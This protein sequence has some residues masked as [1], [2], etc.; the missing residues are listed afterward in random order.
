MCNEQFIIWKKNSGEGWARHVPSVL[1]NSWIFKKHTFEHKHVFKAFAHRLWW[2]L[3]FSVHMNLNF[4]IG[5]FKHTIPI[6]IIV[7][8]LD[9][10]NHVVIEGRYEIT[11]Y[12]LLLDRTFE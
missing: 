10:F 5:K 9:N 7:V 3:Y 12:Y 11:S 6:N 8:N 4:A 2:L 1:L